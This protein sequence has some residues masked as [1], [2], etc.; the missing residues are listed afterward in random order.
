MQCRLCCE[1]VESAPV[2]V[3]LLVVVSFLDLPLILRTLIFDT[4]SSAQSRMIFWASAPVRIMCT[5][6]GHSN[7]DIVSASSLLIPSLTQSL[8]EGGAEQSMLVRSSCIWCCRDCCCAVAFIC[9]D[10]KFDYFDKIIKCSVKIT[11]S[12]EGVLSGW[13]LEKAQTTPAYSWDPWEDTVARRIMWTKVGSELLGDAGSDIL[14]VVGK[15]IC[16]E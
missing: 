9:D 3:A 8:L 5:A 1:R 2:I 4:F 11:G 15:M 6:L 14:E 12:A 10:F 16:M 7:G 13:P